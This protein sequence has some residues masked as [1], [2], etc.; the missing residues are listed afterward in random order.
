MTVHWVEM[1]TKT[2][3]LEF[4]LLVPVNQIIFE[5]KVFYRH[6][7]VKMTLCPIRMGPDSMLAFFFLVRRK[8][9]HRLREGHE[10]TE[11]KI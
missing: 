4:S 9:G 1:C 10:T 8:F 7:R 11:A 6:N 5:N 3:Q 2:E